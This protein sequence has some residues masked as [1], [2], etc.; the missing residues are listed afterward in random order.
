MLD[1]RGVIDMEEIP[2]DLILN[3]NQTAVHYVPVSNWTMAV[4]G[5]KKVAIAGIDDKRQITLVLA[6]TMIGKL[7]LCQLVYQ[8]KRRHV[9][10]Q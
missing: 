9:Y 7:L 8:E 4:E 3:W 10:L 1:I 2:Q 6:G 5:S